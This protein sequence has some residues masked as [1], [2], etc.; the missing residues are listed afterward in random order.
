MAKNKISL[1]FDG[2]SVL[3]KQLDML[4]GNATKTAINNALKAS[5]DVVAERVG[6]AMQPH[7]R[8]GK[9]EKSI[10][11]NTSGYNVKWTG[12]TAEISVG[13]S[14]SDGGMASIFLMYGT[15]LYGQP[16]IQPDRQLYNAVYGTAVK[17]Q[18]AAIQRK[19]F[20]KVLQKVNHV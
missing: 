9:T 18:I 15:K 19:E 10:I 7:E 1:S 6:S 20:E 14:I 11:D 12:N 8:T 17:K 4:G 16:H 13:F 3:K 5:Q 2:Y